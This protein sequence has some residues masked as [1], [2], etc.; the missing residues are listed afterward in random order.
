MTSRLEVLSRFKN[1]YDYLSSTEIDALYDVAKTT[2]L[3]LAFPF[4]Q[5]I[6]DVPSDR[7]RA[8]TWIYDCMGEILERSGCSSMTSYSENGLSISWDRT[9]VSNGLLSRVTPKVGVFG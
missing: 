4:E 8:Y 3:D 7:P 9:G 1:K 2:Y 6:T 5:D